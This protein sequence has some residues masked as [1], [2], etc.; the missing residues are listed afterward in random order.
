MGLDVDETLPRIHREFDQDDLTSAG[1]M[2]EIGKRPDSDLVYE[3]HALH[4]SAM[5]GSLS[6]PRQNEYTP[7][8]IDL[9]FDSAQYPPSAIAAN[10]VQSRSVISLRSHSSLPCRPSNYPHLSSTRTFATWRKFQAA[11]PKHRR[12]HLD[13]PRRTY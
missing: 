11:S 3:L 4:N 2:L 5:D 9:D 10:S 12:C 1:G 13:A 8:N 6:L 7:V